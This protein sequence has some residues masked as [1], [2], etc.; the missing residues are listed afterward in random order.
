MPARDDDHA[1]SLGERGYKEAWSPFGDPDAQ[2]ADPE[3][4]SRFFGKYRGVV[5]NNIDPL[6]RGRLLVKVADPLGL[7]STN[8]AM[9]CVP[10]AG[11]MMNAYSRPL[12]GTGVWVE[13]EQG[14]PQR[15]I[16]TGFFW[17]A[18]HTL[19]VA[20]EAAQ[21]AAPVVPVITLETGKNGITISEV[22]LG[23]Y[24]GL[25]LR[26]GTT[27]IVLT[28]A[29]VMITAPAFVVNGTALVVTGP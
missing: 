19:G 20:A 2:D 14:D 8:W 1:A 18:P 10:F 28:E 11:P 13:F 15:P 21:A 24:G 16:W 3:V 4:R 27:T 25:S 5:E 6:G 12:P 22:P 29:G 17:G 26:V 7:I 9:P 23:P